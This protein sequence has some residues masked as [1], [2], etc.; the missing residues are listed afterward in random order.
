MREYRRFSNR[1]LTNI[2]L[3]T[4]VNSVLL[5]FCSDS[6]LQNHLGAMHFEHIKRTMV[7][8]IHT[9]PPV[10][11]YTCVHKDENG[12]L[13]GSSKGATTP[14]Q[15]S[16]WDAVSRHLRD[17]HGV[18]AKGTQDSEVAAAFKLKYCFKCGSDGLVT[19]EQAT[20]ADQLPGKVGAGL[21]FSRCLQ[22]S[23]LTTACRCNSP[24]SRRWAQEKGHRS[25]RWQG[26]TSLCFFAYTSTTECCMHSTWVDVVE[27]AS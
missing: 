26:Q 12:G 2:S 10:F 19:T 22:H 7:T 13:C 11:V 14:R 24:V 1:N 8:C 21:L 5:L 25:G 20:R 6:E 15:F 16:T 3:V 27:R 18:V 9:M 17:Q 4:H 23:Q